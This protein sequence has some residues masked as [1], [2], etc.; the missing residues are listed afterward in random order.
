M[1]KWIA[2][3]MTALMLVSAASA[4][5]NYI[6]TEAEWAA[7][8]QE[9]FDQM[10]TTRD[11]SVKTLDDLPAFEK[12]YTQNTGKERKEDL[13]FLSLPMEGDL[14]Y[15]EALTIAK[16]ALNSQF[17]TTEE[18]LAAMGVYPMFLDYIY[19][20][21]ESEW[22]FYFTPRRDCDIDL[23]HEIPAGGE[24]RVVL[25]AQTGTIIDC[26]WYINDFFP[27]HAQKAWDAGKQ[28]L[29]YE[30]YMKKNFFSM[31][32]DDQH[33]FYQLLSDAGYQPDELDIVT[34]EQVLK[35]AS[36][37]EEKLAA[38][39]HQAAL[40]ASGMEE[41]AF[42]DYYAPAFVHHTWDD[43]CLALVYAKTADQPDGD[44]HVYQVTLNYKTGEVVSVEYTNGVG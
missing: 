14:P 37:G 22:E 26:F 21:N 15:E 16:Q 33:H 17:G 35:E 25:G 44:N 10:N 13:L 24:Y 29:V 11:I 39:A 23:D 1:K 12:E 32:A 20:P 43:L 28:S 5:G 18:D 8:Y 2:L 34:S 36:I 41:Q 42:N 19:M 6:M 3:M 7:V 40:K 4:E 38:I 30:W 31:S 9:S 27:H